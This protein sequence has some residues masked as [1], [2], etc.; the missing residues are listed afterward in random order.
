MGAHW[1]IFFAS[2]PFNY[3]NQELCATLSKDGQI[4]RL[5]EF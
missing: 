2:I 5:C 3:I 1:L 4:I